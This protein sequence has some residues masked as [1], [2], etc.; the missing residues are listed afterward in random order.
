MENVQ[1]LFEPHITEIHRRRDG[2]LAQNDD[3]VVTN[4]KT[5][6]N[7]APTEYDLTEQRVVLYSVAHTDMPPRVASARHGSVRVIGLF[8]DDDEAREHAAEVSRCDPGCSL[9][10]APAREWVAVL[11]SPQRSA[12][13][14]V[15]SELV[16]RLLGDHRRAREQDARAF[17][18]PRETDLPVAQ[19]SGSDGSDESDEEDGAAPPPPPA[20][21]TRRARTSMSA[22]ARVA[23]QRSVVL[24]VV[25]D[26]RDERGEFIIMVH[27]AFDS[28]TEA[29]AWVR[30][31]AAPRVND[32]HIDVVD[33]CA[34]ICPARMTDAPKEVFRN[35]ELDN[36]I[37]FHK[38]EPKRVAEYKEW[39]V[40]NVKGDGVNS[41]DS[42]TLSEESS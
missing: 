18:E 3:D 25:H 14:Q 38:N 9:L 23:G 22:V 17:H 28:V 6:E 40:K 1:Q 2:V 21:A 13:A 11:C 34:W 16:A 36:I 4:F 42:L 15:R 24:S 19:P 20:G 35:P 10:L 33:A 37:Q 29:D 5:S 30:N 7:S 8:A 26:S 32:V 39:R 12:D 31:V 27:G 41:A